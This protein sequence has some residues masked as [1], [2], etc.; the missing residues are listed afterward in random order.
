M[1]TQDAPSQHLSMRVAGMCQ[2]PQMCN[3][4]L[5]PDEVPVTCARDNVN[6]MLISCNR[7][8]IRPEPEHGLWITFSS[9]QLT[10][11]AVTVPLKCPAVLLCPI[12]CLG[13]WLTAVKGSAWSFQPGW[14]AEQHV[15]NILPLRASAWELA[16]DSR[17]PVLGEQ[18]FGPHCLMGVEVRSCTGCTMSVGVS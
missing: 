18:F 2:C 16:H 4:A 12:C 17:Q 3:L 9:H 8:H 10:R 7:H 5:P 14:Q 11:P 1:T 15:P 6:R 13:D